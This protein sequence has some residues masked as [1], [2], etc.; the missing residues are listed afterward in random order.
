MACVSNLLLLLGV[1]ASS[2][3]RVKVNELH[4][5]DTPASDRAASVN[6]GGA[7]SAAVILAE[8]FIESGDITGAMEAFKAKGIGNE[9][10][11][12]LGDLLCTQYDK[13]PVSIYRSPVAEL[14]G[15]KVKPTS[16]RHH[17]YHGNHQKPENVFKHG[18]LAK[19]PNLDLTGQVLDKGGRAFRGTSPYILSPDGE[20][21]PGYFAGTGGFV[22][23]IDGVPGWD[24]NQLLE[25]KVY[26]QF[27][28]FGGNPYSSEV[29]TAIL[30]HV[31]PS[32]IKGA[33]HIRSY[34]G[35]RLIPGTFEKNPNYVPL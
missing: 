21:G 24:T 33:Y 15:K 7:A 1:Y 17:G 25:G 23:E 4:T 2:A 22:Y 3:T 14:N 27:T 20:S 35:L 19:G 31:P 29:E 30:G 5:L 12:E 8:P 34:R 16:K 26:N 13:T 9:L 11:D 32:R 10:A 18:F 28:G 6:D